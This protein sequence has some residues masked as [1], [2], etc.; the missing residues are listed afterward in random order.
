MSNL[1][2]GNSKTSQSSTSQN[3]A[4]P[5]AVSSLGSTAG[6]TGDL[7]SLLGSLLSGGSAGAQGLASFQNSSGY[8]NQLDSGSRAI[9][10]N[11]AS[12]GLLQSG[13]TG[14]ALS[15]YGTNLANQSFNNYLSQVLG[16]GNQGIAAQNAITAAG[17][18]SNSK[19]SGSTKTGLGI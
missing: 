7:S 13:A 5:G 14:Q 19:G 10:D 15:S 17:Q 1:L 11:A 9:T 16:A 2:G 18:T 3:L 8:Q 6:G 12:R 4:Y